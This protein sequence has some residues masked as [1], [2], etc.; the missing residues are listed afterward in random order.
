MARIRFVSE[1]DG[2]DA[3]S[4]NSAVGMRGGDNTARWRSWTNA[5][6]APLQGSRSSAST[7]KSLASSINEITAMKRDY[8]RLHADLKSVEQESRSKV[9]ALMPHLAE[10]TSVGWNQSSSC[11]A[12]S[13]P[14]GSGVLGR[15]ASKRPRLLLLWATV[16]ISRAF[17]SRARSFNN[18]SWPRQTSPLQTSPSRRLV[19]PIRFSH[20]SGFSIVVAA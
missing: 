4:A 16:S 14:L 7:V 3:F 5:Q 17:I 11:H 6:A 19:S 20:A 18:S 10:K 12:W 9:C 8:D 13:V 2:E 1:A 15:P